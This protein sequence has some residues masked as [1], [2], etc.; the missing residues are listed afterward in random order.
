MTKLVRV[1]LAFA[2]LGGP[3]CAAQARAACISGGQVS[4]ADDC[5]S[6]SQDS[7]DCLLAW[8]V[9]FDGTGSP[10]TNPKTGLP[11]SNITC[12]DGAPC[13]RDGH[14]NGKC[15]FHVGACVNAGSS[16]NTASLTNVTVTK[17]SVTDVAKKSVKDPQAYYTRRTL[18]NG[19]ESILGSTEACTASDLEVVVALKS[20]S[21]VCNSPS[22]QKCTNDQDCDDYCN[23]T[24]KKNKAS[25]IAGVDDGG[26]GADN[27][28]LKFTC[29]PAPAGPAECSD[30]FQVSDT[31]DLIGGELAQGRVGDWMLRNG[32]VRVLVR[33]VGRAH[34]FMRTFGGHILDADVVRKDP[35]EDRDSFNGMQNLVNI[36]SSQN[37]QSISVLN[38]GSNC[39]PGILRTS[40]PDDLF[41]VLSPDIAIFSASN[42]LSVPLGTEGVDLPL[43]LTT[44]YIIRPDRSY[45]QVATTYE[46]TGGTDLHLFVG[47]YVNGSGQVEDFGPGVGFG[48]P[49]LR[50]G[51]LGDAAS[52]QGLDFLAF[53]GAADA[54][55]VSYGLV[56][57]RSPGVGGVD[58]TFYTGAFTQSGVAAWVHR[59]DLVATLLPGSNSKPPGPFLVPAN[60]T[61]TFRRWFVVGKTVADVTQAREELFGVP[62]GIIQGTVTSNGQPVAGVHVAFV[63]ADGNRCGSSSIPCRNVFSATK[64]DEFGFYRAYLPAQTYAVEFRGTGIPYEGSLNKP[65]VHE[66][67]LKA[68][69]T[70]TVDADFP[71]TGGL[72]VLVKDQAGDP[73]AAKI[74]VVGLEKSP[75]PL[76]LD[77]IAGFIDAIGRY[78]GYDP[79]EKGD[80]TFG[81][82][83]AFFADN[84]GDSGTLNLEPGN[85]HIVV[86]HGP[87]YDA[88]AQPLTIS[89]GATTTVN[90]VVHQVVDTAGFVSMDTHVHA[91]SSPDSTVTYKGRIASMLAEGVDFF[92]STDHDHIHDS[93]PEIAE[94]GASSLVGTAPSDEITTFS[95][96]HFNIWPLTV[97]NAKVN[98]G[99]VDWG[100]DG[101][102]PGAGYPSNGS[103]DLLP[104]EIFGGFDPATHVIQINHFNSGTL[105]HFNNLGIDTAVIPP[106]STNLVYRCVGGDRDALPCQAQICLGGLGGNEL[107]PCT[108]DGDCTGSGAKCN[109]APVG[110]GCPNGT[111]QLAGSNL[112]SFLRMDP[113]VSNLYDDGYTALELWIEASRSQ[114]ELALHENL[115]NWI[116]LINQGK[117]KAGTADS[118]THHRVKVQSG[119]PRTFVA[120][121]TDSPGLLD[122][123]TLAQNVNAGR[124][125]G[126][127]NLFMRVELKGDGGA[128]ASHAL[129]NPL[130]VPATSG[131]GTVNVHVEAPTWAQFDRI[132]IYANSTPECR[133][134]YTFLGVINPFCDVTP[135]VTLNKGSGFTINTVTGVS[136]SG[137]RLVADVVQPL[138][139][140]GDTWVIVVARGTDGISKPLF[141]I[142]PAD[143]RETGNT[144]LA[145]L[146]DNG[147]PLPWN[148][149]EDGELEMA[150]SNPLFFDREN[151]GNCHG[152]TSCP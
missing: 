81:L 100:R 12:T 41:D 122:P 46:N 151:D 103:Y 40:G 60:G 82:A 128:T 133:N 90:A 53:Q 137:Q 20:K 62:V 9:D 112:S 27:D 10:P 11:T 118:D 47:D 78:F 32:D 3:L 102:T 116:G 28:A 113:A 42:A 114:T 14:V 98:G 104:G 148:L 138:T 67:I 95:Y 143:L 130:T 101:T 93:S 124:A 76:N 22:G 59:T 77:S 5:I 134:A 129:G 141:P 80:D 111:C 7:T 144:T 39:Q 6:G 83:K 23:L 92:V 109:V 85:Y 55:G 87:E 44:D 61:N 38:D 15:T 107:A 145:A 110:R 69:K 21:G 31:A 94:M 146:T 16:C 115:A 119:S 35:S 132:E 25:V 33:D 127:G 56:F 57:P 50:K 147:G 89:A 131:T 97:N 152:G 96:G 86:S 106:E 139:I 135:I 136:G 121:S 43:N 36:G 142:N 84:S 70:Y 13:D 2:L 126:S 65:T 74:S 51:G 52:P 49:L 108:T 29:E 19:I 66:V 79:N 68:K 73:I 140:T 123:A 18:L 117:F 24:Y 34:S 99:A 120:S 71:A 72:H 63:R 54:S 30:V 75:D 91:I 17:P 150:I 125:I 149:G 1:L 45:V 48:Q 88:F 37:T 26:S 64:T 105:G 58:G 4:N 8:S